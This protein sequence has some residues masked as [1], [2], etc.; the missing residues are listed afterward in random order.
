M[1]NDAFLL[2]QTHTLLVLIVKKKPYV[3]SVSPLTRLVST[4]KPHPHSGNE[5]TEDSN[6][7]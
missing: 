5:Q 3:I 6:T 1:N 7:G 2:F 4:V